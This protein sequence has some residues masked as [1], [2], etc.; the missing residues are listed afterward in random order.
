MLEGFP[1]PCR[2]GPQL[3]TAAPAVGDRRGK[4]PSDAPP[5]NENRQRESTQFTRRASQSPACPS[6]IP[7]GIEDCRTFGRYG[8]GGS[9][10]FGNC[11]RRILE[12]VS[13]KGRDDRHRFPEE[14]LA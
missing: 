11:D 10:R 5:M 9:R 7:K 12:A 1:M 6:S 3:E 14:T 2:V 13:R 4:N 8:Q